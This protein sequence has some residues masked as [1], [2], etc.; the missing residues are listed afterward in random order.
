MANPS[1]KSESLYRKC[2]LKTNTLIA[3]TSSSSPRAAKA[4]PA[5]SPAHTAAHAPGPAN[6]PPPPP[7]RPT[8]LGGSRG[9]EALHALIP[10]GA[11]DR[12]RA[13]PPRAA[14]AEESPGAQN[15][16]APGPG[17]A[18]STAPT[19]P[20]RRESSYAEPEA[21]GLVLAVA[22][23]AA[24][25]E[26]AGRGSGGGG[27]GGL[28]GGGA[29]GAR[30]LRRSLPQAHPF[31]SSLPPPPELSLSHAFPLHHRSPLGCRLPGSCV[32]S[33][34][35]R[36]R[37]QL[38]SAM[39]G[40]LAEK[41]PVTM[42]S[43]LNQLP[44]NL[45]PEEIPSALNLFSGSSDSVA[46]YNQ[47]ATENVMDIGL[48]NEKPNPE[49]SYS[50]SFQPAPGNKTVTYLG[51]FAFD[52]PSNW[53]QDNIISLMSAGIL[54][55]PPASG[56]LSTQ[57]STASMVQPPQGDVEA[58]YPA[59]PP[60][61]NCS[62]LYS[63]PVSFHDPQ[64][65]P[66]LAYS[67]QDYQS[68]K[69]ALDSN[70]FPMIPDYNLYHHPNDMGSMPEHKPFQGMDPIRVNP[71]PIT[72]LETIKAFKDKQ[73]HPGFGSLPQPPLTLKPIRPR[74][75]PNRPSKTPLHERPHACPAEGCDRRFSRSDELT[76]HLRIHT[77]HKPFQCRICMRSFSRSD[78]LTTHI[79]TH[80]GEKPF[81]CEFCGRK[82]ARSDE[83]KRHAKIHLKQKEKK[84][85]KGGAPSASSAAPVSL[86]PVVTT[87]A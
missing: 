77:G 3:P 62:D 18:G 32:R 78:H 87:C 73:I 8:A 58:M 45:Y 48:T 25:A 23:A 10:A 44:D 38:G 76:R 43:L 26:A 69:P 70:L 30:L 34:R 28:G 15:L 50:G 84:A 66:G 65:N 68:A 24:A 53:C 29:A 83:R 52:S 16:P 74:K 11:G 6:R 9:R 33:K 79:R 7:A 21:A 80:T 40:K 42:S 39:T 19:R 27:G 37:R 36:R 54:G 86:A 47:M 41:L 20:P 85:E 67:P 64:G 13:L 81:A 17:T 60:Y 57:T 5:P 63:E 82:F 49:L 51:K 1:L 35:R 61:S 22:A 55:V 4:P 46:H 2:S 56:A 31:P 59:L 12:C 72:P 14:R 75:Y 71:P